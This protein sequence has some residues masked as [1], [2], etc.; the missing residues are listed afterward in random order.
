MNRSPADILRTLPP[1][2]IVNRME[3]YG[4]FYLDFIEPHFK[5][6]HLNLKLVRHAAESCQID[7]DRMKAFH[8]IEYADCHKRAA[9]TMLWIARAHPIQLDTN[10]NMTEA[11]LVINEIYALGLGL[12]HL[13][14][15]LADI[16]KE[17]YRNMIYILHFR[18]PAAEIL[19][20]AM[21]ILDCACKG[22]IP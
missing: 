9:F 3:T 11:L 1:D 4:Q 7:I 8:G 17:Y 19:A 20:S 5:N 6:I 16:S 15:N 2:K 14:I 10:A 22:K 13:N 18:N 21:Y 12:G